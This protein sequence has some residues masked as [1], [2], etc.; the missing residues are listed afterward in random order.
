MMTF[1]GP[2]SE[3]YLP[4]GA[5]ALQ[6]VFSL[7]Q[8]NNA[9]ESLEFTIYT[10][11]EGKEERTKKD[12]GKDGPQ[13]HS[14]DNRIETI[15][16]SDLPKRLEQIIRSLPDDRALGVNSRC[17]LTN[18]SV[19]HIPM[20]DFNLSPSCDSL[21]SIMHRDFREIGQNL[22]DIGLE[23]IGQRG[24]I[25]ESGASYHFYGFDLLE[26]EHWIKFMGSCLL[27]LSP[28]HRWIGHCLLLGTNVLRISGS[29]LKPM[30]PSYRRSCCETH[31]DM[32]GTR[33]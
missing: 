23:N 18:G 7:P 17:I 6:L 12:Q 16:V 9:L 29:T 28:D 26:E 22:K 19:R 30:V 13:H 27:S 20:I 14:I 33:T 21:E 31:D 4:K 24:L 5:D 3:Y 25:L 8:I 10:P 11:R 15:L 1:Q 32:C 2:S